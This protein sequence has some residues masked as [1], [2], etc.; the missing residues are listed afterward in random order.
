MEWFALSPGFLIVR[1]NFLFLVRYLTGLILTRFSLFFLIPSI[2]FLYCF[3][4]LGDAW[5]CLKVLGDVDLTK[6]YVTILTYQLGCP[7]RILVSLVFALDY[8][9]LP[10]KYLNF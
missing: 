10:W 9:A 8:L 3:L 7:R 6:A 1:F 2:L 4:L 5:A